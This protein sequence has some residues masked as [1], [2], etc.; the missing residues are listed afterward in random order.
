[1]THES[2]RLFFIVFYLLVVVVVTNVIVCFVLDTFQFALPLIT[3]KT[4]AGRGFR[5]DLY[6]ELQL[7]HEDLYRVL[8][9]DKAAVASQ[10]EQ[11]VFVFRGEL[12]SLSTYM[13]NVTI[14]QKDVDD[15]IAEEN[16][17][18]ELELNL[19]S[20]DSDADFHDASDA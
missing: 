9:P 10:M 4:Q 18:N 19:L 8:S 11:T 17:D 12:Q 14:H 16:M 2:S 1:M 3:N 20:S 7:R 5:S 15:W 6:V 13:I